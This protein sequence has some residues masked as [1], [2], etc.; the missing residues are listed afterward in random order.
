MVVYLYAEVS[1]FFERWVPSASP[2]LGKMAF[3]CSFAPNDQE[4]LDLDVTICDFKLATVRP[5][6]LRQGTE[7]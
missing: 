5:K 4:A 3:D 2:R 7:Q 6:Q 1:H